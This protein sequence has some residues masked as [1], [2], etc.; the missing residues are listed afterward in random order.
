MTA[1]SNLNDFYNFPLIAL[2]GKLLVYLKG[3][4][5]KDVWTGKSALSG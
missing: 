1:A 2:L 4:D 5:I 3:L